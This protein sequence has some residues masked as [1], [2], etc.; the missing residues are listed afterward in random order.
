MFDDDVDEAR[1]QFFIA[2]LVVANAVNMDLIYIERAAS[3]C[4]I[5]DN[6][7][8]YSYIILKIKAAI[9][10]STLVILT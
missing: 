8:E 9:N 10:K 7:C 5:V 6:D 2:H 3:N 4:A 1:Y